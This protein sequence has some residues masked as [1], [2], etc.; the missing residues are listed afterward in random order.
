[1]KPILTEAE[2]HF[3]LNK[4]EINEA[5]LRQVKRLET[6]TAVLKAIHVLYPIKLYNYLALFFFFSIINPLEHTL[7]APSSPR[8]I[9]LC[10]TLFTNCIGLIILKYN[11]SEW[12]TASLANMQIGLLPPATAYRSAIVTVTAVLFLLPGITFSLLGTLLLIPHV[13]ALLAKYLQ[14][15][16]LHKFE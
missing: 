1:M 3:L 16:I 9:L 4:N 14:T 15:I 11:G 2:L 5:Q 13:T 7:I 6:C 12:I 10:L 8:L